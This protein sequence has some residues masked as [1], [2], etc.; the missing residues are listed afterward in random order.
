MPSQ[1]Y[2]A[3][4]TTALARGE[5][6]CDSSATFLADMSDVPAFALGFPMAEF[7]RK[8][9]NYRWLFA[10]V[11]IAAIALPGCKSNDLR[12]GGFRDEWADWGET[13]QRPGTPA[14][15]FGFSNQARQVEKNLGV[16]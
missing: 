3:A 11:V 4:S 8:S 1:N 10:G 7:L 14:T 9:T 2:H 5:R 15:F 6:F 12:G 13:N 16:D